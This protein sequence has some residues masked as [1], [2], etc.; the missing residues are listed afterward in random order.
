MSFVFKNYSIKNSVTL[1]CFHET[2][3]THANT[4]TKCSELWKW[5]ATEKNVQSP[6]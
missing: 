6:F 2:Q 3:R 1:S 5:L 4:H